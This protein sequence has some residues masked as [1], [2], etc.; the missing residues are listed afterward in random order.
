MMQLPT[1]SIKRLRTPVTTDTFVQ[2][3]RIGMEEPLPYYLQNLQEAIPF[4]T[5]IA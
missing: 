3:K 5:S 4:S 2:A 1:F